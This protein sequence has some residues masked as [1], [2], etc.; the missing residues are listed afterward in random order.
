MCSEYYLNEYSLHE[1]QTHEH[2]Q[3]CGKMNDEADDTLRVEANQHHAFSTKSI[4]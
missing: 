1:S 3:T 2:N 4:C